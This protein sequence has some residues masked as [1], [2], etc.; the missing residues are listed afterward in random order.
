MFVYLLNEWLLFLGLVVVVFAFVYEQIS[1]SKKIP[2]DWPKWHL[3][4][5]RVVEV[6]KANIH[7]VLGVLWLAVFVVAL[8]IQLP[9]WS[10]FNSLG[11]F[12]GVCWITLGIRGK[13]S[14]TKSRDLAN[15]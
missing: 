13:Y 15:K 2:S 12:V 1:I 3:V 11:I 9:N 6:D 8:L 4:E 10:W 5:T 7:L 14:A